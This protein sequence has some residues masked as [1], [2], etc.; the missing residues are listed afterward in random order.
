MKAVVACIAPC[1]AVPTLADVAVAISVAAVT[2]CCAWVT[3]AESIEVASA[4]RPSAV[5]KDVIGPPYPPT[6]VCVP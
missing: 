2:R 5:F 1:T 3:A 4:S 6:L